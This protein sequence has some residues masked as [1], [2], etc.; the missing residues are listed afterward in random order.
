MIYDNMSDLWLKRHNIQ[1]KCTPHNHYYLFTNHN[2]SLYP[3][4]TYYAEWF[5]TKSMVIF[6]ENIYGEVL[7]GYKALKVYMQ[8]KC[9]WLLMA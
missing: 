6:T 1:H 7:Q 2:N 8:V 5:L 4:L 9:A 3:F